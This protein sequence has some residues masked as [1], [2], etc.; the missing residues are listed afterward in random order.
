MRSVPAKTAPAAIRAS[1]VRY[2][3]LFEAARDGIL[4]VD[5][6]TGKIAEANP[7]MAEL[8]GYSQ[9]ELLGKELWEIGLRQDKEA[10][11][12]T[13]GVLQIEHYARYEDLPLQN[14]TGQRREVEV[15]SNLYDEN[16]HNVI[17]CNIRDISERK[18]ADEALRLLARRVSEV[19][20]AELS[21]LA[22]ELYEG[23][24]Q[25]LASAKL[26]LCEVQ[27]SA[28]GLG[29]RAAELLVH[30]SQLIVEALEENRRIAYELCADELDLFGL[31][32]ACARLC[33]EFQAHTGVPV[34][35]RI[36]LPAERL[37]PPLELNLFRIVELGLA[38]IQSR[39]QATA[40]SLHLVVEEGDLVLRLIEKGRGLQPGTFPAAEG[41]GGGVTLA[42]IRER[43][44]SLGG[45]CESESAPLQGVTVKVRVPLPPGFRGAGSCPADTGYQASALLNPICA[46]SRGQ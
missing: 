31:A 3:R 29:P 15:V 41:E 4:I 44:F 33:A 9:Q 20:E 35:C 1:E 32:D 12:R 25:I 22:H 8:L 7:F 28:P 17:Q 14:K 10:S 40:A 36:S 38:D 24:N 2:R 46:R 18:R 16:G 42:A 26:R 39:A 6:S 37:P 11:L 45:A 30:C 34:E 23:V 21:R 43:A 13:L 5:P 27:A 19:Q